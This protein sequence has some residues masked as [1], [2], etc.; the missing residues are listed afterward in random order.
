MIAWLR[1][2]SLGGEIILRME[3]LDHPKNKPGAAAEAIAD[4]QWLGFNWD[5][6][7]DIGGPFAPYTQSERLAFYRDALGKLQA[8]G[9]VY[10]C[11][12]T[13]KDIESAQSAPHAGETLYY[14]GT[15]AGKFS[16]FDEAMDAAGGRLP[17]WRFRATGFETVEFRDNFAGAYRQNV[18]EYCG[19]FP[20]A[21]DRDGAGY[22]LAVAVDDYAM[23]VTEVVRGDDLLPATPRQILVCRALGIPPPEY[24]H[25]PIVTGKDGLRLAK[26]HGDTRIAAF[27]EAGYS[28]EDVIGLLA[29]W[30]G[31]ADKGERIALG[32]LIPRFNLENIP[33]TP[34]VFDESAFSI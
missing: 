12:C 33:H 30:S 32:D 19:D 5:E 21:R 25:L 28:P 6:G 3:D 27:R 16:S 23:G 34:A 20:L 11:I 29:S 17:A 26:R 7:P 14:A 24:L 8:C 13:R 15:C 4:L 2:R 10:P 1:A 9:L 22:M 18:S 31:M